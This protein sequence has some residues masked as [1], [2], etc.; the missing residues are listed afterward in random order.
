MTTI[1]QERCK[2]MWPSC[3]KLCSQ[4]GSSGPL[5][6]PMEGPSNVCDLLVEAPTQNTIL[7]SSSPHRPSSSHSTEPISALSHSQHPPHRRCI[8]LSSRRL[9]RRWPTRPHLLPSPHSDRE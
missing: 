6:V 7:Y 9:Q 5:A 3:R 1:A 2:M 8:D 4:T